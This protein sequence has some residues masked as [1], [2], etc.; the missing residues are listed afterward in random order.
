MMKIIV[1][2][3]PLLLAAAPTAAQT[4]PEPG[5]ILGAAVQTVQALDQNQAGQIWDGAS[6]VMKNSVS[7]DRFIALVAQRQAQNGRI[8]GREWQ[9]VNRL[10]VTTAKPNVPVGEY[11]SITFTGIN[12]NRSISHESVSFTLDADKV[13]RLVGYFTQ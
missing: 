12:K 13:W 1:S 5:Q 8:Q 6:P 11:L 2:V 10:H 3:V 7:K 4:I 9:S